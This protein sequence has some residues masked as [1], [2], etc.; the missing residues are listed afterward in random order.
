MD[1]GYHIEISKRVLGVLLQFPPKVASCVVSNGGVVSD[2]PAC[3]GLVQLDSFC[4][5]LLR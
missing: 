2:D 3:D 4:P 1:F 5:S